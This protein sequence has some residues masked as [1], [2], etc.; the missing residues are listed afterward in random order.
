MVFF[1]DG[2]HAMLGSKPG[3]QSKVKNL[4]PQANGIQ[5]MIYRYALSS[6]TLPAYLQAVLESVVK[7]VNYVKMQ[8][9][10]IPLFKELCK[11]MNAD[12]E[13]PFFYTAV[14]WL[15]KGNVNNL[16]FEMKD[17]IKPG[18]SRKKRSCRSLRR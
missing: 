5:C 8:A 4:A 1:T 13:V 17:E 16:V 7:I 15:S 12:H 3:F 14:R 2:A 6:K 10:N 9:P 11:G 18:D